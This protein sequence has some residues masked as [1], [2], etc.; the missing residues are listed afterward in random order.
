MNRTG[1]SLRLA[2][3]GFAALGVAA[4]AVA[5]DELT[6]AGWFDYLARVG[7]G[8][9][10]GTGVI[11]AEVEPLDEN[12][13]YRPKTQSP[14]YDGKTFHL[15]SGN[16]GS[17]SWHAN[18][19]GV[20]QFSLDSMAPGVG[21]IYLWEANDWLIGGYLNV[22]QGSSVPPAD[23]P[24][25]IKQINCSWIGTF[26]S[27]ATDTEA[28]RR[29]DYAMVRDDVIMTCGIAN[30]GGVNSPL[31]TYM[32][33]GLCVGIRDGLH[34]PAITP[35]GLDGPGR[36]KP[37]LVAPAQFSSF[38]TPMVGATASVLVDTARTDPV[39]MANPNAERSEVVKACILASCV[40][41]DVADGVWSN[42][43]VLTGPARG[44]AALPI[45]PVVG[46]GT[47]NIDR[48]HLVM[49]GGEQDGA[50]TPPAAPNANWRGWDLASVVAGD[51]RFY[52]IRVTEEAAEVSVTAS[53]HRQVRTTYSSYWLANFDLRLWRVGTDGMLEDL[54]GDQFVH[55]AGG[56]VASQS[57]GHNME[58]LYVTGLQPGEYVIELQRVDTLTQ[59]SPA[60]DVALAWQFPEPEAVYGD[61]DGD[62]LVGFN[63]LVLLLAAWG[64]CT[65]C[66]EDINGDG[67]VDFN[68]LVE[69]LSVWS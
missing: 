45:D 10:D 1:A 18:Q 57:T 67:S 8:A 44:L 62:G 23:L 30:A 13:H 32:F 29:A 20:R 50:V 40:H 35:S 37:D 25:P 41:E 15:M 43:P 60:W 42:N 22:L 11:A 59:P 61:V 51:S 24:A 16:T 33:N 27:S 26:G 4:P 53:W 7:V 5:G 6:L 21:E 58:H 47:L 19:V 52:R 56:N 46:A 17:W 54:I 69:M 49:T 64:E 14:I 63:D 48:A 36:L 31:L 66:A 65:G 55:Y 12:G 68:D 28:L 3:V 39:L 2:A 9:P 34:V 38:A